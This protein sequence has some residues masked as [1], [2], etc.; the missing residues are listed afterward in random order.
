MDQLME[1]YSPL[2]SGNTTQADK[3]TS[4]G[5]SYCALRP[6]YPDAERGVPD[7]AIR[8]SVEEK[9]GALREAGAVLREAGGMRGKVVRRG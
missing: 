3:S 8:A 6:A 2:Q 7:A 1:D 4:C 9:A 5:R